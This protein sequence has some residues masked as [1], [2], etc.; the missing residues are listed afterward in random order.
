M[1][2]TGNS[3]RIIQAV[4]SAPEQRLYIPGAGGGM[5]DLAFKRTF[6]AVKQY[7][8]RL[9]LAR[10][11]HTGDWVAFIEIPNSENMFPVIGFGQE[12][13][14][15]DE[16][17]AILQRHSAN[18]QGS[19]LIDQIQA[20]NDRLQREARA[21]ADEATAQTMEAVEFGVRKYTGTKSKIFIP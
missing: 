12:L 4:Q 13:P 5:V 8:D 7:D 20:T 15:P 14:G 3:S 21:A 1:A 9:I 10:H 11:E 18:A 19:K 16:A 6:H 2:D 17:R